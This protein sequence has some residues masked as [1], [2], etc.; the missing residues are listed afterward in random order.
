SFWD[1]GRRF[2]HPVLSGHPSQEGI[3]PKKSPLKRGGRGCVPYVNL[4]E[5]YISP[6]PSYELRKRIDKIA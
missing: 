6:Y 1:N 3:L 5:G 2:T 4:L